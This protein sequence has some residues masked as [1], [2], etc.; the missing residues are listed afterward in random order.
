MLAAATVV[1]LGAAMVSLAG[2]ACDDGNTDNTDGCLNSCV[3]ASCGD[4][5]VQVDVES[6]DDGN[7]V[8][9]S[10]AYGSTYCETCTAGHH[11]IKTPLIVATGSSTLRRARSVTMV[12]RLQVMAA[13]LNVK[14]LNLQQW[15]HRR[16]RSLRRW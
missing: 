2:E 1:L 15:R 4:G 13:Q 16:Q 8:T 5:F 12:T 11:W 14:G 3:V 7:A 10:A 9:E 6:C